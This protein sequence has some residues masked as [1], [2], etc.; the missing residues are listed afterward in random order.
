MDFGNAPRTAPVGGPPVVTRA[1]VVATQGSV[2]VELAPE[3]TVQSAQAGEAVRLDLRTQDRDAR[4]RDTQSRAAFERRTAENQQQQRQADQDL[5]AVVESRIVIEPRTRAVVLQKKDRDTG[6]TISQL[7]DETLL[8]LRI[9]SRELAERAR[10][11]ADANRQH[12]ER[13]A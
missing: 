10:D 2:G 3:K 13:I 9:Y 11:T 8:K 7:P 5:D 1:D 4:A 12:V 6:E